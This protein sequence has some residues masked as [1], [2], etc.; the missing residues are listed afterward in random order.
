[1]S[2]AT[3]GIGEAARRCGLAPSAIRYYESEGLI[4]PPQR[5]DGRRRYGVD[6][7]RR[8][9]FIARGREMGLGLAALRTA[10]HPRPGGWTELVDAQVAMLDTQIAAAKRT[11]EMLMAS[12]DCPAPVPVR[13]CP[14]LHAALDAVVGA[15]AGP[16][17]GGAPP[18]RAATSTSSPSSTLVSP[19][20]NMS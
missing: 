2:N 9:A 6:E 4:D 11:R 18:A 12:R 1:M 14:Y 7:L 15:C 16:Q 19:N 5:A 13:D 3:V 17:P 8:L 20:P 10:L